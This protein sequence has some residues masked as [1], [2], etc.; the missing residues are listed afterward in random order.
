MEEVGIP[1]PS[2]QQGVYPVCVDASTASQ[3]TE[4]TSTVSSP[5]LSVSANTA[6]ISTESEE[7]TVEENDGEQS[8][9]VTRHKTFYLEDGN[10]EILCGLTIFR[11]HT[12]IISFVSSKLRDVLSESMVTAPTP[13]GCP[14]VVFEDSAEDF[15]VLLKTIYTPG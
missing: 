7:D 11:V 8:P 13:G 15:G 1:A 12:P 9:A 10:V 2:A 4:S 5:T 3:T 6:L 14:R